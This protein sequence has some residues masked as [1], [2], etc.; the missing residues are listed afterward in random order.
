MTQDGLT[1]SGERKQD[2]EDR[3]QGLYRSERSYGLFVRTIPIPD[4]AKVEEA[5]ATF[6]DG[7][8]TVT[9]PVEESKRRRRQIPINEG[10]AQQ[11]GHMTESKQDPQN[12]PTAKAR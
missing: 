2:R 1:I 11:Q 10:K 8:L 5:K 12:A 3:N 9:V 4:D 6:E 7:V